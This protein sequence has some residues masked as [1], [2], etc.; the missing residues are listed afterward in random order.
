MKRDIDLHRE[1]QHI[2]ADARADAEA[3][4]QSYRRDVMACIERRI[5]GKPK[6]ELDDTI[7]D[8]CWQKGYSADVCAD[9]HIDFAIEDSTCLQP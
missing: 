1:R 9:T 8:Q 6:F 7:V 3:E 2:E 5:G 4:Y